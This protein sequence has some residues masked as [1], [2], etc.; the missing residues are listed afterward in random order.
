[1]STLE[2]IVLALCWLVGVS[3]LG[4]R[5]ERKRREQFGRETKRRKIRTRIWTPCF[6]CSEQGCVRCGYR[7][8]WHRQYT[9]AEEEHES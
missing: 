8:G 7:G 4:Y 1:M 2:W 3:A 5:L 6:A 9:L